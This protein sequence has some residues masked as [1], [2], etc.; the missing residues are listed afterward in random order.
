[1]LDMCLQLSPRSSNSLQL[2]FS[3]IV[4][5]LLASSSS[6]SFL[7]F[8]FLLLFLFLFLLLFYLFLFIYF[9]YLFFRLM[10]HCGCNDPYVGDWHLVHFFII[11]IFP[12]ASYPSEAPPSL[13]FF[14]WVELWFANDNYFIYMQEIFSIKLPGDPKL[15]EGK[16]ENQNHAIIFT[17]G[18]A[19]QTIDMNQVIYLFWLDSYLSM[20][21]LDFCYFF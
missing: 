3:V 4:S 12:S 11:I 17:R 1:M 16:P 21:L 7:F 10:G 20:F 18:E 19:V 15:G 5:A 8:S 2:K 6:S 14:Y 13:C 9:I